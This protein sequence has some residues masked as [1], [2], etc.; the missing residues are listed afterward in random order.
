MR[1]PNCL[2]SLF[3]RPLHLFN[4]SRGII[5]RHNTDPHQ[6]I[7]CRAEIQHVAVVST[8]GS[9]TQ[10]RIFFT[11]GMERKRNGMSGKD[12]LFFETQQIHSSRAIRAVKCSQGLNFFGIFNKR[13]AHGQLRSHMLF[14]VPA[15]LAH[16]LVYFV[17]GY[18]RR[19]ITNLGNVIPQVWIC[20]GFQKV[21][22]LHDVAVGVV[23]GTIR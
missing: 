10:N 4:G 14:R 16:D 23:I 8:S 3:N 19:R 18:H 15:A 17:I 21:R 12:Q 11:A 7:V 6:A 22:Q 9:I 2:Q 1:N 20:I 5:Q 13:I